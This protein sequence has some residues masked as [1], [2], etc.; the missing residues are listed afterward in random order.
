MGANAAAALKWP[1]PSAPAPPTTRVSRP[2]PA[3]EPDDL[4]SCLSGPNGLELVVEMAHDLRSPLTSILFLAETLERGESGP[5]SESQRRQLRL[6]YSAALSLCATASDVLELARGSTRL[7]D[8]VQ[9]PFSVS[10]VF[11]S[12]RSM[13]LP[14]AEENGLDVRLVHPVPD[15][16]L[17]QSRALS[18]ALLNLATNAVKYTAQ[19][20]VEI[21]AR[22]L[23][24]TRLEFSVRDTG[25]GLEPEALRVLYQPFGRTP[26]AARHYF[27]SSG[28]GLAICRKLV[29]AMGSQLRVE[30]RR[31]WGTR[32]FME[33]DLPP[34]TSTS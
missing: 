9:G 23:D 2:V 12:V 1:A 19:G 5:V 13:V 22:T 14:I 3:P 16:R 10:D 26:M 34:C 18:R 25:P 33:L 27:S 31:G 21:A 32:F 6:M 28:L 17:G 11:A 15:R 29:A 4:A 8:R 7:A 20:Y 30:S 24:A